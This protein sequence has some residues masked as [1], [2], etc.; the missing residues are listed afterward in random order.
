[1]WTTTIISI[2]VLAL[3]ILV[4]YLLSGNSTKSRKIK[5]W[6]NKYKALTDTYEST[7]KMK[8]ELRERLIRMEKAFASVE[9]DLPSNLI[10]KG[11]PDV[12]YYRVMEVDKDD[13]FTDYKVGDKVAHIRRKVNGKWSNVIVKLEF[14]KE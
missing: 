11:Y 2:A 9:D 6:E 7:R 12:S 5:E 14:K 3:I 8:F 4:A 10:V 1:M 13:S